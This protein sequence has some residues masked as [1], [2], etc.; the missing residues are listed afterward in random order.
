M[1]V[2][3]LLEI[4]NEKRQKLVARRCRSSTDI[5]KVQ[6]PVHVQDPKSKKLTFKFHVQ[7]VSKLMMADRLHSESR[8]KVVGFL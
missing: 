7:A 1:I 3:D 8:C 6:E 2:D 5:F 4:L